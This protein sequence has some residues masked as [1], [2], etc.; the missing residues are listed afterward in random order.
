MIHDDCEFDKYQVVN[1]MA[2]SQ[3]QLLTTLLFKHTIICP[4]TCIMVH[5]SILNISSYSELSVSCLCILECLGLVALQL[6]SKCIIF[7]GAEPKL[8]CC[9]KLNLFLVSDSHVNEGLVTYWILNSEQEMQ[10]SLSIGVSGTG[11]SG[12]IIKIRYFW[13]IISSRVIVKMQEPV[14]FQDKLN[15]FL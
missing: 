7:L 12:A 10:S 9:D 15:L 3:P 13:N 8:D 2:S 14:V 11:S 4:Y 6:S 1:W 5:V